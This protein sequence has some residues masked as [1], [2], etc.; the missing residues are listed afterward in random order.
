MI[1]LSPRSRW[2]KT[3]PHSE[4]G[5]RIEDDFVSADEG[6]QGR[7]F[8]QMRRPS[9]LGPGPE[10]DSESG[11]DEAFRRDGFDAPRPPPAAPSSSVS[12][13]LGEAALRGG[14]AII[15]AGATGVGQA[16]ERFGFRNTK[17]A[18]AQVEQRAL[19]RII[20]RPADAEQLI[21][22]AGQR[23]QDVE[24]AAAADI[25]QFA[26]EQAAAELAPLLA[27]KQPPKL[28]P[29]R[30][31]AAAF[32]KGWRQRAGQQQKASV[33]QQRLHFRSPKS[34]HGSGS[35]HGRRGSPGR[36]RRLWT[37]SRRPLV[38]IRQRR[39][40]GLKLRQRVSR[41]QD[42]EQHAAGH[43]AGALQ[44]AASSGAA[45][46]GVAPE[47]QRGRRAHGSAAG[48]AVA[49]GAITP[50]PAAEDA[51]QAESDC[52]AEQQRQRELRPRSEASPAMARAILQRAAAGGAGP[53]ARGSLIC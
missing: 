51:L 18:A 50:R 4:L 20:G 44:R 39:R 12:G 32:W 6:Y 16:V 28:Q 26:A 43:A 36:R 1:C 47:Q 9:F 53:R 21:I 17:R 24:R 37:V 29:Q 49:A 33:L 5:A 8:P 3:R 22:R 10:T 25:E 23:A 46:N 35:G 48:A 13:R 30:Q 31:R 14:E 38:A 19:P 2:T 41:H 45:A 11:P 42:T 15:A 27:L 40:R 34:R 52:A 7:P